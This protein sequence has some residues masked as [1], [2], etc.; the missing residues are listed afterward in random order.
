MN[1][2]QVPSYIEIFTESTPN[3]KTL[4][5]LFNF[6]L[7]PNAILECTSIEQTEDSLL[8]KELLENESISS[9]F[10]SNNYITLTNSQKTDK[11]WF[12]LTIELKEFF[13]TFFQSGKVAINP[14]YKEAVADR[15]DLSDEKSSEIVEKIKA[16][17]DKYV[18]PA[19]E[20]DG[21]NIAFR[22]FNEG[23]VSVELQGACSGCPSS[24][25]TLKNGI[26]SLLKKMV[27]EVEE[28]VAING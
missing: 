5:F 6:M 14:D 26:E 16:L 7:L 1:K 24:T 21:G 2:I 12:E 27:P 10:I 9:V 25:I 20:K 4:K 23:V 18:K 8:A 17:L 28:V 15:A 19:V 3:P 13:K 22:N 11:E